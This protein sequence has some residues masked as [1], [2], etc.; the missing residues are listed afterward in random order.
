MQTLEWTQNSSGADQSSAMTDDQLGS[1]VSMR[2]HAHSNDR[3]QHR[4]MASSPPPK[5]PDAAQQTGM[6]V[7]LLVGFVASLIATG[8]LSEQQSGLSTAVAWMS[9]IGPVAVGIVLAWIPQTR[10]FGVGLLS[11]A[12]ITLL[13]CGGP[14]VTCAGAL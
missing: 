1:K 12:C 4:R 3:W 2:A 9:F 11:G 7:G 13:I 5:V 8:A 10:K 6:Q 14:L